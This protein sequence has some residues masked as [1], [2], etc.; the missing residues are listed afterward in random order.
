MSSFHRIT[1]DKDTIPLTAFGIPTRLF[2]WLV[3][4]QGSNAALGWFVKVVNEVIRDLDRVAAYLDDVIVFDPDPTAHVANIRSLFGRLRKYNFKRSAKVMLGA[5]DDD[6]LGHTISSFGVSPNADK[7]G[8]LTKIP[9]PKNAKQTPSLLGGIGHYR[10]FLNNISTR[11]RSINALL[12]Q[13]VKFVVTPE[14]EVIVR[15][16]LYEK[17]TPPILVYSDWDAV[18]DNSRPFR[19][20]CDA[21]NDGFG[22]TLEQ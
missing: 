21:S 10:K 18:T 3:M 8:T 1:I 2:E 13:G 9:M 17:I 7:V 11:L 20:Y 19:L 16:I 15:G 5:T 6:F 22:T 12:K 4:P 14:M